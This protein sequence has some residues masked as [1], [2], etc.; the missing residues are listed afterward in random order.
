MI[1]Y[2]VAITKRRVGEVLYLEREQSSWDKGASSYQRFR[3][4]LE[5]FDLPM[6]KLSEQIFWQKLFKYAKG[7]AIEAGCGTG[8]NSLMLTKLQVTPVLFDFS[9]ETIRQTK[10][11]FKRVRVN[12]ESF[13][14]V[15]DVRH[16]PF[17]NE[18]FDFA[19]SDSTLEHILEIKKAVKEIDRITAKG[20]YVFITVPNKLRIDG[21]E[22]WKKLAHP[23]YTQNTYSPKELKSLF[24]DT[25]MHVEDLFG[26][27]V[28]SPLW[29]LLLRRMQQILHM[30]TPRSRRRI[31][32]S[33]IREE[34]GQNFFEQLVLRWLSKRGFLQR[35][36]Q[37]FFT[38]KHNALVS[39]N[40]A[41]ILKK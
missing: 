22:F 24:K 12:K 40:L 35:N 29:S 25:Q 30:E 27:D 32:A 5:L 11:I 19:H 14:V 2:I 15:G 31:T 26:Y 8:K 7:L 36:L 21:V 28:L 9:V 20:G 41:I 23:T 13:F 6:E 38:S 39:I 34:G 16:M 17:R 33:I 4:P 10:E 1:G 18:S 37:K 3:M